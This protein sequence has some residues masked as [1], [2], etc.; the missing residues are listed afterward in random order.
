[1]T[2]LSPLAPLAADVIAKAGAQNLKVATAE[3]CTG[4]LI[5]AALTE[6]AGSSVAVERGFVTYSNEAKQ[7]LLGVPTELIERVGAVSAEVAVAMVEGAIARSN[8]DIAVSVTG[9]AGPGGGTADKPVGLVHFG[10]MRR[11]RPPQHTER[12]FG[13]IGRAEIR[14]ATV[15]EALNLMLGLM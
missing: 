2:D 13:D 7:E 10:A 14:L 3:S 15:E 6:I 12:L 9:V 4:G 5:I 1:M 11:D 8:A